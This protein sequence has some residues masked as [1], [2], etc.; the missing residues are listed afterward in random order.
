MI[1]VAH[2]GD[3]RRG[4]LLA[5]G[6]LL[7]A[8]ALAT[9][10]GGGGE[11]GAGAPTE[12]ATATI[13]EPT[14]TAVGETATPTAPG[15]VNEDGQDPVFWRTTDNFQSLQ[16]GVPYLVVFRITSG[17]AEPKLRIVA[18]CLSCPAPAQRQPVEFEPDR[19]EPVGE[20]APG[21][22]YAVNIELP[23]AGQWEL[24]VV[25]GEDEVTIPVEAQPASPTAG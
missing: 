17:Y 15:G 13:G 4:V 24:T 3:T 9:A 22:Y 16:A 1:R 19:A 21:S 10:C 7:L 18:T 11:E 12:Q 8:V 25:A 6:L 5:T 14:A 20:D 23:F 2:P